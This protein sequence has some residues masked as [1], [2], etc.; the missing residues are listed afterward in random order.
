MDW[1]IVLKTD[2]DAYATP[3]CPNCGGQLKRY[4]DDPN[5][6]AVL[7]CMNAVENKWQG[8]YKDCYA[9]EEYP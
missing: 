7:R 2:R 3:Y 4:I 8:K 6:D 5:D 9:R 1:K